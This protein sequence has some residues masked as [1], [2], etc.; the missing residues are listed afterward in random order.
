ME[1][2]NIESSALAIYALRSYTH[3]LQELMLKISA[4]VKHQGFKFVP[5][6]LPY[7]NFIRNGKMHFA[8]CLKEENPHFSKYNDFCIG[9]I[10]EGLMNME[11]EGN[12]LW[13]QLKLLCITGDVL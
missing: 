5:T 1:K 6:N 4:Y 9:S 7:C 10:S 8:N 12:S 13:D 11:V 3:I 2:S